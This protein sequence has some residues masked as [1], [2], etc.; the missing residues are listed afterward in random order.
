MLPDNRIAYI[1][2][3]SS[4][5]VRRGAGTPLEAPNRLEILEDLA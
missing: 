5:Q 1:R 4:G 2:R 3:G